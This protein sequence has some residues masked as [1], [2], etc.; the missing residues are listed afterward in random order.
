MT[1]AHHPSTAPVAL[2]TGAA[3]RIGRAIALGL[4]RAGWDVAVHYR[5]SA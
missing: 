5:A 2:V 4:A 1:T 3:R